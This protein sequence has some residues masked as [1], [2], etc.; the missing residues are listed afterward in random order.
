MIKAITVARKYCRSQ[1]YVRDNYTAYG[2]Q[3]WLTQA[4]QRN[5]VQA[6]HDANSKDY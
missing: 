3:T 6:S 1:S 2:W 4:E 5:N